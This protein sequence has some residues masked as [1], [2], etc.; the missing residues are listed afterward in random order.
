[1]K[2]LLVPQFDSCRLSLNRL[3]LEEEF[4]HKTFNIFAIIQTLLE[5]LFLQTR[6]K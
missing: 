5:V 6:E 1:M 2:R 4:S 3:V